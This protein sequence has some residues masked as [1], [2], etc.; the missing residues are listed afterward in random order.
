[1]AASGTGCFQALKKYKE[2]PIYVVENHNEILPF[3]YRCIGSKHLPF[4]GNTIVHLDSHPDMLIPKDMKAETVWDKYA[5]FDC[6]S[7][8]N[9]MLPAA[10]AGHFSRLIWVKPPWAN[11]I[12]DGSSEFLI[13]ENVKTGQ[14]RLTSDKTY[15]VS[16][17]LWC[18]NKDLK[19]ARKVHL[20]VI[21][22]GK[23]LDKG[24]T[25]QDINTESLA[26]RISDHITT[27]DPAYVLDI[28]LDFF[29]TRDPFRGLYPKAD[30]HSEL[31]KL[32][33][34]HPVNTEDE[35][36]LQEAVYKRRSQLEELENIFHHLQ[37]NRNLIGLQDSERLKS[38][39]KVVDK[40]LA[41][42]PD[43]TNVESTSNSNDGRKGIA[44]QDHQNASV[45]SIDDDQ[46]QNGT[47]QQ[48]LAAGESG[49]G[50]L[51]SVPVDW[52]LVHDAGCTIDVSGLP[53]HPSTRLLIT[54]MVESCLNKLLKTLPVPPII[55]TISRS[56][57]DNYCPPEDVDFVQEK[58]LSVLRNHYS[59]TKL[60]LNYLEGQD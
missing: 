31:Q 52:E 24:D 14:I 22:M 41:I 21:T 25:D 10:Y 8:E 51:G 45:N 38:V 37:K 20:E 29:S 4:Q 1:M 23:G 57:E 35:N 40:V 32:Y 36:V 54:E 55:I 44:Q 58:V 30:L 43:V 60:I 3:I 50:D 17:A 19:N 28:D 9:W 26:N 16:E 7:I 49:D 47:A 5:L 34:Y 39:K 53:H 48:S 56:S 42:Y 27:D 15:F 13:G 33:Y 2:L 46:S 6:L 59:P 18:S 11:Q 12:E